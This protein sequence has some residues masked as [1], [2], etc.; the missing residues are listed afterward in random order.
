MVRL[1]WVNAALAIQRTQVFWAAFMVYLL[2]HTHIET[3]KINRNLVKYLLSPICEQLRTKIYFQKLVASTNHL[4]LIIPHSSKLWV[5]YYKWLT[6][7]V[8]L[9]KGCYFTANFTKGQPP[10]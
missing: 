8:E 6:E 5:A 10:L 7:Y 2:L 1:C 3:L 4:L 9:P